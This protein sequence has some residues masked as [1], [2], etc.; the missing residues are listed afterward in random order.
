ME[1]VNSIP[2]AQRIA[3]KAVIMNEFGKILVLREAAL[4]SYAEG[5]NGGRWHFPGG[6]INVG[7]AWRD[8]LLRE[9]SEETGIDR[10]NVL[11]PLFVGEWRPEIKGVLT[12]IVA[13]FHLCEY[14]GEEVKLS[15]EHDD[16]RWITEDDLGSYDFVEPDREVA[17]LAFMV[18]TG[19]K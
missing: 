18:K 6:R 12:Q 1:K 16:F 19:D 15:E 9:V 3:M 10:L 5:S 8:G 14:F 7:E 17:E 13:V 4:E 2:Q 11:Q